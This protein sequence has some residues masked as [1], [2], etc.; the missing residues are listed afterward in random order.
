MRVS[1]R[2][3]LRV[4]VSVER[5]NRIGEHFIISEYKLS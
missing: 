3:S 1:V 4:S 5:E 2:M